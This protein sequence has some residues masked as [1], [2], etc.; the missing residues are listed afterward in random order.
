MGD[1][2]NAVFCFAGSKLRIETIKPD[3]GI[4]QKFSTVDPTFRILCSVIFE[5]LDKLFQIIAMKN[6]LDIRPKIQFFNTYEAGNDTAIT[7]QAYRFMFPV[8]LYIFERLYAFYR[9]NIQSVI[10]DV[11]FEIPKAEDPPNPQ[12]QWNEASINVRFVKPDEENFP[13]RRGELVIPSPQPS[14]TEAQVA[15]RTLLKSVIAPLLAEDQEIFIWVATMLQDMIEFDTLRFEL[16]C[17]V[18]NYYMKIFDW[19]RT[20]H[21]EHV[22]RIMFTN[23]HFVRVNPFVIEQSFIW[24]DDKYKPFICLFMHKRG[25]TYTGHLKT[26]VIRQEAT[27]TKRKV[28][29]DDEEDN[30]QP[31]SLIP[32]PNG[33]KQRITTDDKDE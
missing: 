24:H 3:S 22:I 32:T 13:N 6:K 14:T 18:N 4:I 8:P 16:V 10:Q 29:D 5:Y 9:N 27:S 31:I 25:T 21:L 20:I 7:L 28:D 12:K 23:Q 17:E 33:K 30:L 1:S 15:M 19:P 2:S 26:P 11:N